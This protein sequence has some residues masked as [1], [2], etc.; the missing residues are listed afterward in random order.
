MAHLAV[1]DCEGT[2]TDSHGL[3]VAAM[4]SACNEVIGMMPE[5]SA[6]RALIGKN[7]YEMIQLLLQA[8]NHDIS[9][10]GMR[11][12]LQS[13]Q[14]YVLNHRADDAYREKLYDGM[15]AL[16]TQLDSEEVLLA[17]ITG[18]SRQGLDYMLHLHGLAHFFTITHT[19]NDGVAKPNPDM[20]KQTMRETGTSPIHTV[21]IGDTSFDMEMAVGANAIP[22]GV[23]WGYHD[24]AS[25]LQSGAA[26]VVNDCPQL[27][28]NIKRI[29]A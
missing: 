6:I 8:E 1:F 15:T 28:H 18:R 20:L 10:A 17:I 21:M 23:N 7:E 2:L 4:Q 11:A 25:L 22:I 13:Y 24:K 19:A 5:A 14:N 16:L 26:V 12:M 29:F 27:L 9:D 3:V